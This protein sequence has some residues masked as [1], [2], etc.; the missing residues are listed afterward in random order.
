MKLTSIAI[1]AAALT[2]G[3][4][5]KLKFGDHDGKG[6]H[7][8]DTPQEVVINQALKYGEVYNLDLNQYED[9]DDVS[10]ITTQ[11]T[12]FT[13]SELS[14]SAASTNNKYTYQLNTA[15]GILANDGITTL[16]TVKIQV[17]EGTKPGCFNSSKT[18][19]VEANI[20]INFTVTK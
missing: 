7:D 6:H 10:A 8:K 5:S 13:V 20:T 12:K 16:E 1:L 19:E 2:L 3:S 17:T 14:G 11:A 4:C 9:A 15:E 18:A